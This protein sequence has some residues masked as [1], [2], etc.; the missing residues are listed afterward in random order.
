MTLIIDHLIDHIIV[1]LIKKNKPK[2]KK[3]HTHKLPEYLK[4][5][6]L[7]EAWVDKSDSPL[8][9]LRKLLTKQ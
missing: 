8:P 4:Q 3:H 1:R 7:S 9:K 6:S 2:E 5:A